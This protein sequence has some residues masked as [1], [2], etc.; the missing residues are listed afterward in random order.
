MKKRNIGIIIV[1][2]NIL[3]GQITI[4]PIYAHDVI[5]QEN[6]SDNMI[7]NNIT[8]EINDNAEKQKFSVQ[9]IFE[10]AVENKVVE[11]IHIE[12]FSALE[13]DKYLPAGYVKAS[14]CGWG[15]VGNLCHVPVIKQDYV[16]D[17]PREIKIQYIDVN[18]NELVSEAIM[19]TKGKTYI[20][21]YSGFAGTVSN[22]MPKGYYTLET[23]WALVNDIAT[24]QIQ[25][26]TEN[27]LMF[28]LEFI[29]DEEVI[30][31]NRL[32]F[33]QYDLNGDKK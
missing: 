2:M 1:C 4:F 28:S 3:I 18:T 7:L 17:D 30:I 16:L 22:F 31:I 27:M 25:K 29:S 9:L 33:E 12:D 10:D 8:E 20:T 13:I 23:S 26:E 32:G 15:A 6:I 19:V 11:S 14:E 5:K 24:I 21:P